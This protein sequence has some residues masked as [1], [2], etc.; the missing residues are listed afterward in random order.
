MPWK[1]VEKSPKGY[2]IPPIW[3]YVINE[4]AKRGIKSLVILDYGNALYDDGDKPTS[5]R[6]IEAY[7]GYA[8]F[9][10]DHFKGRVPYYEIWNEYELDGGNTHPGRPTN[11]VRMA[12]ATYKRIK[13]ADPSTTV[14]VGAVTGGTY[15]NS[16]IFG[17]YLSQMLKAGVAEYGDGFSIHPYVYRLSDNGGDAG[18]KLLTDMVNLI[19]S[20]VGMA[21]KKIV[22]SEIGWPT[23]PT[24]QF[25]LSEQLQR[26]YL[27]NEIQAAK[28]LNVDALFMYELI[29]GAGNDSEVERHFGLLRSD[30]SEKPIYTF[31]KTH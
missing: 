13:A 3:D 9:V 17:S 21:G 18:A 31:L 6:A 7:A 14:L 1:A 16:G 26:D 10:A 5:D 30:W 11:Y 12:R 4:S 25:A 2:Q 28:R 22:V 27:I 20:S 29:D 8:E 19:R 24:G 23:V 15:Y